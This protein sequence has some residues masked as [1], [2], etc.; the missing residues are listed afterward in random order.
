MKTRIVLAAALLVA[1]AFAN[2]QNL[3]PGKWWERQ[4]IVRELQLSTEQQDRID[5]VFRAA[6]NDLIDAR[7]D[8]DKLQIALRGEIDRPQV[9][10]AEVLRIARQLGEAR[11]RLFEREMAMLLDMRSVLNEQQWARMRTILDRVQNGQ[12][13]PRPMQRR[14][15]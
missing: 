5:D 7:A 3:P 15:P 6:A 10:R 4:E 13:R 2:A 14:K 1:A 11:G 8:V 12:Q 9:R